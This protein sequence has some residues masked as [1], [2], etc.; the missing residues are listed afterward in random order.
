[1][2]EL[3]TDEIRAA[4]GT[5]ET[6]GPIEISRREIVKYSVATEQRL[7][8]FCRGDEAPPMF[9]FGA[10]RPILTAGELQPDGLAADPLL[11]D[12]PL[13]R[14]M[15]GGT[16]MRYHRP[17]RA[18]DVLTATRTLTDLFEKQGR[19]GPLIFAVFE[20]RVETEAGEAIAEEV[21]TRIVR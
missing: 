14:V 9:L 20:L 2:G 15:A 10:I 12:L 3:L 6:V 8:R 17:V 16:K 21:Q 5:T 19:S 1:M 4:I 7:D 18:G 11:P 13:R